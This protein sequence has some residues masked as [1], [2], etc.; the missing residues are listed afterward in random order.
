MLADMVQEHDEPIFKHLY[1]I[2]VIFLE[3]DPM[4]CSLNLR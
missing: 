3:K 2:N 1:D 4:V